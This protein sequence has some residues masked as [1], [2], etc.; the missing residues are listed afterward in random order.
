MSTLKS[1]AAGH[2]LIFVCGLTLVWFVLLMVFMGI[3]S[4]ALRRPYGDATTVM[5]SRFVVAACALALL[6]GLGWLEASGVA[7]LGRWPIWLLALGGLIYFAGASLYA[8]YGKVAFDV[9]SLFRLPAARTAVLAHFAASLNE[10]I[11]FRGLVLYL[12]IRVWGHTRLGL[13]GSVVLAALLFA[14][15]HL[16]QIFTH[17]VSLPLALLLT[18]QVCIVSIWWGALVLL[19][20][21]VWPAVLLHFVVNAVVAVQGLTVPMIEPDILAYRRLLWFSIPLGLLGI[22]LLVQAALRPIAPEVP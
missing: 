3:A 10:E 5:I 2:P 11:V 14:L 20:G 17:Q 7:R 1:V 9:S 18:V 19:S 15:V 6:W 4:G 16:T 12:L 8:F 13:I 22:G 21:S